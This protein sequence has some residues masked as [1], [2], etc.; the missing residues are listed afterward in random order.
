ML[1]DEKLVNFKDLLTNQTYFNNKC[2]E[3]Q[4][5]LVNALQQQQQQVAP[6][7]QQQ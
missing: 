1:I 5:L 4:T 6:V 3:A 7:Q 2:R